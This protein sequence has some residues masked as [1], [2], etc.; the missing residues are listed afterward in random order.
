L[1]NW[2]NS[3]G[4]APPVLPV[5]VPVLVPPEP[6]PPVPVAPA[7]VPPVPPCVVLGVV[8]PG[9]VPPWVVVPVVLGEVEVDDWPCDWLWLLDAVELDPAGLAS[10]EEPCGTVRS[11]NDDGVTS[12]D[13]LSLPQALTPRQVTARRAST[14]VRIMRRG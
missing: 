2:L 10:A 14:H 13:E 4:E 12:W 1:Q 11:G 6:V 7:P 8:A 3:P 9:D 5:P